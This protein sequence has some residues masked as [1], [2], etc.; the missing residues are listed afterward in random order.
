M[1][2]FCPKCEISGRKQ[3]SGRTN[4]QGLS[5]VLSKML[6][7]LNMQVVQSVS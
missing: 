6:L 2:S 3:T 1:M 4:G 7:V 5:F